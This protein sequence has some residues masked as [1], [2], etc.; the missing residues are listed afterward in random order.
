MF[1]G[2]N[3]NW[4]NSAAMTSIFCKA[5]PRLVLNI[6]WRKAFASFYLPKSWLFCPLTSMQIFLSLLQT[7]WYQE[8]HPCE[9]WLVDMIILSLEFGYVRTPESPVGPLSTPLK[10]FHY[11]LS[12]ILRNVILILEFQNWKYDQDCEIGQSQMHILIGEISSNQ[13]QAFG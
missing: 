3:W 5:L 13:M 7:S 12:L 1:S 4:I 10:L 11:M 6:L 9:Q 2:M 8:L